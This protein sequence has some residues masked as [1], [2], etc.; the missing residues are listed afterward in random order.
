MSKK[1]SDKATNSP[2]LSATHMTSGDQDVKHA[3]PQRL[4]VD[5]PVTDKQLAKLV[6]WMR[7][8]N[9]PL[10]LGDRENQTARN[11]SLND[12][13]PLRCRDSVWDTVRRSGT[14]IVAQ[15]VNFDGSSSAWFFPDRKLHI[16]LWLMRIP[17][18]FLVLTELPFVSTM[19]DTASAVQGL[20]IRETAFYAWV[21][22]RRTLDNHRCGYFA[23]HMRNRR[24]MCR[25]KKSTEPRCQRSHH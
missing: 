21:A 12:G 25:T 7:T 16:L 2:N 20:S 9:S 10:L 1:A 8:A 3:P 14:A 23:F 24:L 4:E 13:R 11:R 6:E 5:E 17:F 15:T 22:V 18:C 19:L